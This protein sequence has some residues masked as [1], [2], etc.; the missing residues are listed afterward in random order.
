MLIVISPAKTLDYSTIVSTSQ[1]TQPQF[2][3][4]A[5][6]LNKVLRDYTPPE[7]AK[8]M[9]VSKDLAEL[10]FTRNQQWSPPFN[11]GNAR[12]AIFAFKGDVYLGLDVSSFTKA[13]LA[14]AQQHLR[15]LSGLY[16]AL[17]P[18]D[19]MQ[20]YRLEMGTRLK[21]PHGSNLYHFWNDK[22]TQA[23][24]KATRAQADKTLINLASEEYFAVLRRDL[25]DAEVITPVFKDYKNGTYKII[26][27]FAKKARGRMAAWIIRNRG[28]NKTGLTDFAEDGYR[29]DPELSQ[30]SEL[31]FTRKATV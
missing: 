8:L 17:R 19:L 2:I 15:I 20:P 12:Q 5:T 18:L 13:D 27:F 22:V 24:N 23:I 21:N 14:F 29:F 10:N 11:R 30:G 26:S 4:E 31:V 1:A 9:T 6:E 28:I 7:L 3:E 16:G 25:L